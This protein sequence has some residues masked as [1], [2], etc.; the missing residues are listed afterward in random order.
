M[1]TLK[2]TIGGQLKEA[3][4]AKG[5]SLNAVAE[6][7]GGTAID[8]DRIEYDV[9]V[10]DKELIAKIANVLGVNLIDLKG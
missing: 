6:A 1:N 8:V 4:V 9:R 7:A 3:R 2:V 5:L 10:S